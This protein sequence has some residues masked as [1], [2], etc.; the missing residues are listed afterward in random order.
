M[1]G[2]AGSKGCNQTHCK[3]A[4]ELVTVLQTENAGEQAN[5]HETNRNEGSTSVLGSNRKIRQD[6]IRTLYFNFIDQVF[7]VDLIQKPVSKLRFDVF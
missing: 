5:N 1:E 2:H 7:A 6:I 3:N 4:M